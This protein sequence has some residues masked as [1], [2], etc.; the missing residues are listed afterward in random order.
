MMG[1]GL[2]IVLPLHNQADHIGRIVKDYVQ[3]LNRLE[4]PFEIVLVP[5][6]CRDVSEATCHALAAE[7]NRIRVIVSEQAGWG[8]AVRLGLEAA[9]G[10]LIC[11][12]NSARTGA[13][14]LAVCLR[15]ALAAP[16]TVVKATRKLRE[17]WSRQL[18][19]LLYNMECRALFDLSC[20]DINGTPKVFPRAFKKLLGLARDDNLIDLEFVVVCR[21][22]GYSMVEVPVFSHR[23]HGGRSTTTLRSALRMY[24]GAF[25][26]SRTW[27]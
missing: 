6:G 3:A 12:T 8:R 4:H 15:H 11:Y 1:G 23:R 19:S 21:R 17:R 27:R 20:W 16:D 5:N 9:A 22:E 24:G 26:L 2:S 10:D 25:S 7:D 18:G 13:D 14:E